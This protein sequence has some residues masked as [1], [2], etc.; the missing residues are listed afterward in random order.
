MQKTILSLVLLALSPLVA[1]AQTQPLPD[2]ATLSVIRV[3]GEAIAS[4]QPD[5]V[6]IEIGVVTNAPTAQA[7]ATQNSEKTEKIIAALRK[8][9]GSAGTVKTVNYALHPDYRYEREGKPQ[10]LGYIATNTVQVQSSDLAGVGKLIDAA[11]AAGANNIQALQ[12][13][14]K[15]PSSARAIALQQATKNAREKANALAQSLGVSVR[16]IISV[17]EQGA[18]MPRPMMYSGRAMA[19]TAATPVEPGALEIHSM[20]VMTVEIGE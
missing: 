4:A 2:R 10:V 6:R 12:F 17:E 19:E 8:I 11:I 9:L 5:E 3:T 18:G 14:L 7:A 13:T 15:D 1:V 20:V 16:R